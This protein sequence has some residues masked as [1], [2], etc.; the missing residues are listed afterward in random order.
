MLMKIGKNK[1]ENSAEL[2]DRIVDCHARIR[3]FLSVARRLAA[4][5]NAPAQEIKEAANG[6]RRYFTESLPRHVVDLVAAEH[7]EHIAVLQPDGHGEVALAF[8][9]DLMRKAGGADESGGQRG[10]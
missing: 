6:V 1:G 5:P 10:S 7:G 2:G 8:G 3:N 4:S 9:D